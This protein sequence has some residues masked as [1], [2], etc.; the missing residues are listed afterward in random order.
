MTSPTDPDAA[1]REASARY[2]QDRDVQ[3]REIAHGLTTNV[4]TAM[5]IKR[6]TLV[7]GC[8]RAQLE[9]YASRTVKEE[10]TKPSQQ[11]VIN[12]VGEVPGGLIEFTNSPNVAQAFG[13][14]DAVIKVEILR[15]YLAQGSETESGWV[16]R[17]DAPFRVVGSWPG[18]GP[19]PLDTSAGAPTQPPI[20]PQ[21]LAVFTDRINSTFP[22]R[23]PGADGA[24]RDPAALALRARAIPSPEAAPPAT[25][26]RPNA[27]TDPRRPRVRQ[28]S[29]LSNEQQLS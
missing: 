16:C 19:D 21:E 2:Q 22:G 8:S 14:N 12:Q 17:P 11:E 27:F 28:Q 13:L 25:P 9:H 23:Q 5:A 7:R 24:N 20:S 29:A 10:T 4:E 1:L 15:I 3:R 26:S 6:V 18:L